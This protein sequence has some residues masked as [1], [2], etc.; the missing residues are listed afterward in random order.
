MQTAMIVRE[1]LRRILKSPR[2]SGAVVLAITLTACLLPARRAARV[3]PI[4][5]LHHE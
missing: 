3:E 2:I 1:S 4:E 5:A